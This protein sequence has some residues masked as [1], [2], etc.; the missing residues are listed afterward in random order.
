M[1]RNIQLKLVEQR[2]TPVLYGLVMP[3]K[4]SPRKVKAFIGG[5]P[6]GDIAFGHLKQVTDRGNILAIKFNRFKSVQTI[7]DMLKDADL[8]VAS[9]GLTLLR[10][11]AARN[12]GVVL[13]PTSFADETVVF[14]GGLTDQYK[15]F[16]GIPLHIIGHSIGASTIVLRLEQLFR[17]GV[18]D[19][20]SFNNG[21]ITLLAPMVLHPTIQEK[22]ETL[23]AYVSEFYTIDMQ[24]LFAGITENPDTELRQKFNHFWNRKKNFGHS[25]HI[26]IVIADNDEESSVNS[27]VALVQK[28]QELGFNAHL[29]LLSAPQDDLSWYTSK[30]EG[31]QLIHISANVLNDALRPIVGEQS[32]SSVHERY[33]YLLSRVGRLDLI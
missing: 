14:L 3:T 4:T 17:L 27:K 11:Y 6:R 30:L 7:L 32:G 9:G 23:V 22:A 26:N 28:L 24:T 8:K 2:G 5:L 18:L 21:K 33:P 29:V 12:S 16:N 1:T 25:T 19:T 20:V 15:E 31:I 10:E 13:S